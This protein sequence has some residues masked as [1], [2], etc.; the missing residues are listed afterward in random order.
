[1]L[2]SYKF[3]SLQEFGEE[4]ENGKWGKTASKSSIGGDEKTPSNEVSLY[5][6]LRKLKTIFIKFSHKIAMIEVE[7]V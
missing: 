4:N 6:N 7:R 3:H 2:F 1:M 5:K